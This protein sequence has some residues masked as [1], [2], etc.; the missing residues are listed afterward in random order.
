M[1]QMEEDIRHP[2][3]VFSMHPGIEH[4]TWLFGHPTDTYFGSLKPIQ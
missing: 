2:S 4:N 1:D 3:L